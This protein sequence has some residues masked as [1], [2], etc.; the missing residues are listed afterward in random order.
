MTAAGRNQV[1]HQNRAAL[2][3][4]RSSFTKKA[5]PQSCALWLSP[6]HSPSEHPQVHLEMREHLHRFLAAGDKF[7]LFWEVLRGTHQ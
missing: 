2:C 4:R 7:W 1:G 5:W 3:G 6:L